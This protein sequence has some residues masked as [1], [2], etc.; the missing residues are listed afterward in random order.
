MGV[1]ADAP[2]RLLNSI[3]EVRGLTSEDADAG[4]P[5]R[6]RGVVTYVHLGRYLLFIQD[7]AE[8]IYV[9]TGTPDELERLQLYPGSW[10]E[11]KGRTSGGGFAPILSGTNDVVPPEIIILG[12]TN[13]PTAVS[14]SGDMTAM[15]R[16]ENRWVEARGVVRSVTW[17]TNGA[18]DD[19][20]LLNLDLGRSTLVAHIPAKPELVSAASAWVDSE[21]RLQGV[22]S[23]D[24]NE[25]R[26]IVGMKLLVQGLPWIQTEKPA[27][28]DPFSTVVSAPESLM[29]FRQADTPNHRVH[30]RGTIVLI[31]PGSGFYLQAGARGIWIS[32][33]E[34]IN[35]V[36]GQD[37]DV[38]GFA[39]A[40]TAN[41]QVVDALVR[42]GPAAV[43]PVAEPLT[44]TNANSLSLEGRRVTLEGT[45]EDKGI[46][47]D[48]FTMVFTSELGRFEAVAPG[49]RN[50]PQKGR[51]YEPDSLVRLT[52]VY[53]PLLDLQHDVTGFRLLIADFNDIQLVRRPPWWNATRLGILVVALA[54]SFFLVG[55][56]A[57]SLRRRHVALQTAHVALSQTNEELDARVA[58]RTRSL[59]T[60][61]AE[62]RRAEAAA[63]AANRAK[64]E[65]IAQMSHE[66]RTP[67]NGIIGLTQLL[68]DTPLDGEQREFAEMIATSGD[69]LLKLINELLDL[70]K[71]EAGQM[72]F[73]SEEFRLGDVIMSAVQ[74]LSETASKKG[75]ALETKIEPG[76]PASVIGDELRIRQVLLNLLGNAVKF[77][78]QG[79]VSLSVKLVGQSGAGV[80]IGFSVI[81]TGIG[82]SQEAIEKL[83]RPYVQA[84]QST[85]RRFGG[86]GLGLAIC[87]QLVEKMGG[88]IGV[89]SEPGRGSEFWFT[90]PFQETVLEE[91]PES[92]VVSDGTMVVMAMPSS[93]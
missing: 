47:V 35:A 42:P 74:L 10:V 36:V 43:M 13:L 79:K 62:R 19:R 71:I 89:K 67:M 69:S 25:H 31:R 72:R 26:Q 86:T 63:E 29:R 28:T 45:L 64:S 9:D 2:P 61:V 88:K 11:V 70:S 92:K 87:R 20:V 55:V 56:F 7:G 17:F 81:D 76:V 51:E 16:L 21:V 73:E 84:E 52:G 58:E 37:V 33:Q 60:E 41:P 53:Q 3:S 46:R 68:L 50:V 4:R 83:F 15:V 22:L 39:A 91:K 6:V 24:S 32:S 30:L 90:I 85:T 65:F 5:Y 34:P 18:L 66:I 14:L 82:L 80:I 54:I 38:V 12:K 57:V 40:G 77:T 59:Q 78:A 27:P 44:S 23:S 48:G 93:I 8:G 49:Y 75:L 1:R